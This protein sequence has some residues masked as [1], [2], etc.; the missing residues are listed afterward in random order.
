MNVAVLER[1]SGIEATVQK[2]AAA[3]FFWEAQLKSGRK[4]V[5]IGYQNPYTGEWHF[6]QQ[7][8]RKM[9]EDAGH[10]FELVRSADFGLTA[11]FQPEDILS[12]HSPDPSK[13]FKYSI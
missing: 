12:I 4:V 6:P 10:F 8:V 5:G 3:G 11:N 7:F 13:Y 2:L 9:G 1:H